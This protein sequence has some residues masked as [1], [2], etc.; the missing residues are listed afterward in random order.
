MTHC[1]VAQLPAPSEQLVI[2]EV[3]LGGLGPAT[4]RNFRKTTIA[5][6]VGHADKFD[7]ASVK[8]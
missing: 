6:L 4:R 7:P 3:R 5:V 8:V 1:P 2:G